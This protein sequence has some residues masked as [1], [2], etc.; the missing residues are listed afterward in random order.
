MHPVE[1]KKQGAE[2]CLQ[3]AAT[4][5]VDVQGQHGDEEAGGVERHVV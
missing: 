3:M 4:C 2:R 5:P 1:K